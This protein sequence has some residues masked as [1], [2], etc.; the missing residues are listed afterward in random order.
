MA[1]TFHPYDPDQALLLPPSLREWLP[2][3][4]PAHFIS[5]TVDELDL[6]AFMRKYQREDGR[7][8]LA[9][10][11]ALMLKLLIYA[12]SIGIFSS[13]RIEA[14][15]DEHVALRYLAAGN[16]P[17]HRTIARFRLEHL[18][19]FQ[20]LF[21]EVVQI[22]QA[23][24]IVKLGTLAVDGTKLKANASKHK[25]M[26]YAR[27]ESEEQRLRAQIKRITDLARS[28]DEAEDAEFGPDF[29]GDELPEELR[30][31]KSRLATIRA[32]KKRLEEAQAEAD[33]K[34]GRGQGDRGPKLKRKNGV[35]DDKAQSNFT[36]PESRIMKTSGGGFEQS[37]NAQIAVDSAE[38]IIVAADVTSCAADTGELLKMEAAAA[39]NLGDHPKH[40]LADAGYKS[41]ANFVELEKLGIRAFVSLG[42][43]ESLP[44]QVPTDRPATQRMA[45]KLRTKRGRKR[46]RQR[47]TV[48][49]PVFGWIKQVLGFRG[50]LLRGARKVKGE[51]NLVCMAMNLKRMAERLAW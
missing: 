24:G 7:G 50:F 2:G 23:S 31:R 16:S 32:V 48:V 47:K 21:V 20:A 25:A 18:D 41:E 36:D 29:R 8:Q 6:S 46:Y 22:A 11:P 27:M 4:H 39:A 43:G 5:D 3:D 33:E 34:S 49:E 38:Q 42:R 17:S 28:T 12:Y 37:Y 30:S 26:S 14:A 9:Y 45:R 44:K 1:Q 35:P 15:I 51:W 13:R 10:H 40:L 19:A